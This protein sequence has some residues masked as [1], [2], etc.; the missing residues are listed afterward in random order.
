MSFLVELLQS[1]INGLLSL[2]YSIVV[3]S[4]TLWEVIRDDGS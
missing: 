2:T 3:L 4:N 1:V